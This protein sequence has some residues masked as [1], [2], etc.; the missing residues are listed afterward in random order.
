MRKDGRTWRS[1]VAPGES[2]DLQLQFL[3]WARGRL[4]LPDS[5]KAPEGTKPNL[6]LRGRLCSPVPSGG[7][8]R[9]S[10]GVESGGR[11]E[12]GSL[13]LGVRAWERASERPAPP[14]PASGT[15]RKEGVVAAGITGS[16][17]NPPSDAP[18]RSGLRIRSSRLLEIATPLPPPQTPCTPQSRSP[19]GLLSFWLPPSPRPPTP[20][21]RARGPRSA[22]ASSWKPARA[23]EAAAPAAGAGA[24]LA[25][26]VVMPCPATT[27]EERRA[28]PPGSG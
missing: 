7:G 9:R 27:R 22:A 20:R 5:S 15:L 26:P 13:G 14:V 10:L 3:L 6:L 18:N 23:H 17:R 2:S 24:P 19:G 28:A 1:S 21:S 4:N 12:R 16:E 8:G 25:V 11:E